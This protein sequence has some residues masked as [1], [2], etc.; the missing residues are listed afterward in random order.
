MTDLY[1]HPEFV[2]D[3]LDSLKE[4]GRASSTIKRYSYD[5]E[6]F[7]KW[8]M[9]YHDKDAFTV[10]STLTYDQLDEFFLYLMEKRAYKVR[11]IRRIISVTKQLAKFTITSDLITRH[12][13]TIYD[14]PKLEVSPLT[15]DEWLSHEEVERLLTS[16]QSEDG[17][18]ENQKLA[19][20]M[21]TKRNDWIFSLFLIYG[22]TL[23]EVARISMFDIQFARNQ[24][25]IKSSMDATK[26][27]T[28]DLKEEDKQKAF[29]YYQMIPEPVR[30]RQHSKEP[31]HIAFDFQRK[32][33]HWSYEQDHPKALT[34]IAIQKMIRNE[35][36][37]A[38]LR[39]GISAQH[40]RHTFILQQL[41]S[42]TSVSE[43]QQ[44]LGFSSA[45]SLDRCL[46][47]L[48]HLNEQERLLLIS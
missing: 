43:L 22:L 23:Q 16:V 7:F 9:N 12:P 33:F 48:D 27:R 46:L 5:L 14:A 6:D 40:L 39:K 21:L 36:E 2:I 31:F 8:M 20:P 3:F 19:R 24:L 10:W 34:E 26:S 1:T 18:T 30:P 47:T 35:V 13:A 28:I 25:L 44:Y 42:G 4:K 15:R 11:T 32:T 38:G 37:R 17:L 29:T 41:C 45:L